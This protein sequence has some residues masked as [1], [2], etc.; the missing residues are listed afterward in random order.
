MPR[1]FPDT[2]NERARVPQGIALKGVTILGMLQA[3]FYQ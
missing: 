2:P 3:V 1:E